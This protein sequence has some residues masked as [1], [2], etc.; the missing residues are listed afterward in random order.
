MK[1]T[2]IKML[3]WETVNDSFHETRKRHVFSSLLRVRMKDIYLVT[4]TLTFKALCKH[5][6]FLAAHCKKKRGEA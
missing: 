4:L 6:E 5:A 2:D 3:C 1:G